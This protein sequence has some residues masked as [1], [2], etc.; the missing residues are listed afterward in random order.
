MNV[1]D[2]RTGQSVNIDV[3]INERSKIGVFT[4]MANL[5]YDFHNDTRFTPYLGTSLGLACLH[6]DVETVGDYVS[7][8]QDY[9]TAQFAWGV[10]TGVSYEINQD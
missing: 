10:S 2:I 8:T 6:G 9:G 1:T 5:Y 4:I 7:M 3:P